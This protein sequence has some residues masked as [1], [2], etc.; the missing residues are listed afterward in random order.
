MTKPNAVLFDLGNVLV[1][2]HPRA[3]TAHLGIDQ[4]TARKKYRQQIIETVQRYEAGQ[5]ATAEYLNELE[6][7]FGGSYT[8]KELTDAMLK[9]IG[10]PI[11]TMDTL[12]A[13]V[14]SATHV[15]LVSNTNELHFALCKERLPALARM[16]EFFLSYKMKTSKPNPLYYEMV[17]K[18]LGTSPNSA[19]F[20]DD[21]EENVEGARSAGM[22]G[23]L[24]TS[25]KNLQSTLKAMG[26]NVRS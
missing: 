8:K 12:V 4:D 20:I 26:V 23:I 10:E 3:F 16:H 11:P 6:D 1:S 25:P 18:K 7:L 15:A 5:T 9:V 17:L 22:N 21:L 14:A 13:S 24:F 19:V 2:I